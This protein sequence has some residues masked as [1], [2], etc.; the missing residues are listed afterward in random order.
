MST[1]DEVKERID[2]VE[3]VGETVRLKKSGKNYTGFCPFHPNTRT[4][5]FVVFPDS[6]T[7]RCFG[8]CNEGGDVFRFVM[9]REGW[10]F[11]EALRHLA[12]RAGVELRPV[13]AEDDEADEH[14]NRLREVLEAAAGF[15][16][17]HLLETPAGRSVKDYLVGRSLTEASLEAF[18]IGY[19]PDSWEAGIGFLTSRGFTP[20]EMIEAGVASQRE[21]GGAIDRFRNRIMFPVRDGRGRM[22]GFGA[23]IVD[24]QDVPKFLN[25]PQTPL[26]D[27]GRLLYGLDR[28]RRAI[29]QAD[30][31][32]VVEGY[33]D[34]IALHQAGFANAVSPMGTAL[35]EDH[36]RMIRRATRRIV[37]ALDPDPAGTRAALRGLDL[38]RQTLDREAEPV[39]D[40]GGFV[41]YEGRLKAE[42]RIAALPAGKDPDEIVAE[43][44]EAWP[45]IVAGAQPVV[46]YVL[47]VL[48]AEANLA[49]PK[50]KAEIARQILP[51]IEDVSD[52][53]E[54]EAYR[55]SMA[56][57]LRVDERSLLG[58]T[59]AA[60][61]PRRRT[62][63]VAPAKGEA[64]AGTTSP[65]FERF[66]LGLLLAHPELMYRIDRRFAGLGIDRLGE[67]DF[68]STDAQVLFTAIRT[69][70]GQD[71]D[72]PASHWRRTLSAELVE[73]AEAYIATAGN[74]DP[75]NPRVQAEVT[76]HTLRLRRRHLE[77]ALVELRYLL[78]AAQE[79]PAAGDDIRRLLRDVQ[80]LGEQKSIVER[81]LAGGE[82]R[83]PETSGDPWR[84]A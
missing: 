41:R 26:F 23:R 7:W 60:R 55:Q 5:A 66:C 52:S 10:D 69:A 51:L 80:R 48:T 43:S 79:D 24:P 21:S 59:P 16:R 18:Q 25:S 14:R 31:A 64:R 1:V 63:V 50:V 65:E 34:V 39:F 37:L 30:Q 19:A 13:R 83:E 45:A 6:G 29:R 73:Q 75:D 68:S 38:A 36:L 35:T 56:R 20:D 40:P 61:R 12:E 42:I 77:S 84:L 3:V 9:K 46:E 78:Q 57:R 71:E 33:L 82:G 70:L 17:H 47:D 44:A 11:P 4:P 76:S 72:E 2:I 53:V 22:A 15:Y 74:E 81:A 49:D 54:R 8:A 67:D 28:A 58:R 62:P 32:V 27:K